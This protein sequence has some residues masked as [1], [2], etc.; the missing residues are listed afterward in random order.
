MVVARELEEHRSRGPESDLI[1][2]RGVEEVFS[3]DEHERPEA[4][5][6]DRPVGH[7][8]RRVP[9]LAERGEVLRLGEV[10]RVDLRDETDLHPAL[11]RLAQRPVEAPFDEAGHPRAGGADENLSLGGTDPLPKE[12]LD[13]LPSLEDGELPGV[14]VVELGPALLPIG[15][16]PVPTLLEEAHTFGGVLDVPVDQ[17]PRRER[18]EPLRAAPGGVEQAALRQLLDDAVGF[19]PVDGRQ[20]GEF[21]RRLRTGPARGEVDA[22]SL[23]GDAVLPQELQQ[24]GSRSPHVRGRRGPD[25]SRKV[26]R[27]RTRPGSTGPPGSP[28]W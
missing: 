28:R 6:H 2:A 15:Q 3:G 4:V 25:K 26:A 16:H 27:G 23:L 11:R 24:L 22:R 5:N 13:R 14:V 1:D 10:G 18:L 12:P 9:E 7:G 19:D 17:F 21:A 20:A 8:A